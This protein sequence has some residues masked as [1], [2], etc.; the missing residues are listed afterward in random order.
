MAPETLV[1]YFRWDYYPF[2]TVILILMNKRTTVFSSLLLQV[3]IIDRHSH[4]LNPVCLLH[5][6]PY[7]HVQNLS[8]NE[9][10]NKYTH[11]LLVS[12]ATLIHSV[13]GLPTK[14]S[15]FIHWAIYRRVCFLSVSKF[16]SLYACPRGGFG[17]LLHTK[18]HAS[19]IHWRL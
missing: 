3:S 15:A 9:R 12:N 13:A 4:I 8:I 11:K 17:C 1:Y 7:N 2:V 19:F 18:R 16:T 14:V 10:R 5:V 6:Q